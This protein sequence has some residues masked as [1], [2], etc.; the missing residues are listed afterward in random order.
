A[1]SSGMAAVFASFAGLLV[2]G[3]HVVAC[4]SIFGSTHQL[5]T[6]LFPRWGITHTYVDASRPEEWEGA[7]R[8]NTKMIFLETP[9]NSG[10]ELIDLEWAGQLAAKHKLILNVD[11][12][13]ATRSE[14]HTSELQ[15]RE[16]LVCRLLLEKKNLTA[17]TV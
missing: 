12:C 10:L 13:F 11:N 5:L 4:R 3:D 6:R 17:S 8:E 7:I 14:E 15:S 16:N 2:A 1:F 9:S